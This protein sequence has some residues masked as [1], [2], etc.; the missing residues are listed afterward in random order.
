M[1]Y[2]HSLKLTE[3]RKET[4]DAVVLTFEV[5]AELRKE[6]TFTPGQHLTLKTTI[7]NEEVRRSYSICAAPFE[8]T[9]SV[10]IKKI[11]N[12]IFSTYANT[13]LS[14]GHQLDV[15]LP[16]GKF[17]PK[18]NSSNNKNY[19]LIAA[20]SG[21][22]PVISIVKSILTQEPKSKVTLLFGNRNTR[23]VMFK[24]ELEA[25]KNQYL[26]RF[27]LHFI[28]SRE[29]LDAPI[30]NGRIDKHK[31]SLFFKYLTDPTSIDEVF[32]C[33]PEEMVFEA[34]DALQQHGIPKKAIH[35]E[36][37]T[38]PGQVVQ[39]STQVQKTFDSAKESM[40]TIKL[41]SKTIEFPLKYGAETILDAA[42][43][44]G[45]DL[46]FSCKGGV[47]CTCRAKLVEGEVDMTRNFGLEPD[48]LEAGF[49]L[50][51]QSHPRS[52]KV[53]VDFDQK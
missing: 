29:K 35:T 16:M 32:I 5:P 40:I 36:L 6:F 10:A 2:F 26:D 4:P 25:L 51:C 27:N 12:G 43:Q 50:T 23:S 1:K 18:L 7:D 45:A 44:Q 15:M 52:E 39:E 22:T 42:M 3:V 13:K 53:V 37:F 33:G 19:M 17:S 46:P 48:E 20:G 41:D 8:D 24:E 38:T 14:K 31:L 30:L 49:I 47:C 28:M 21:I 11:D 9:L 34:Q